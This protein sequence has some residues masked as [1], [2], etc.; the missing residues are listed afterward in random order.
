MMKNQDL[1]K[2]NKFVSNEIDNSALKWGA[3]SAFIASLCCIG[4]LVLVLL[5]IGGASTVLAIGYRKIYFLV[6]GLL[7]LVV[8][9][10]FLYRKSCS[11]RKPLR[12]RQQ[13]LIFGG[14]VVIAVLLYY[15]LTFIVVP[16]LTPLVFD[17]RSGKIPSVL[18]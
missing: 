6:F 14:S 16:F 10:T 15:L 9:L 1:D 4:P 18:S 2:I 17:W 7:V 3:V 13:L 8:G 12:H 5:G 11:N